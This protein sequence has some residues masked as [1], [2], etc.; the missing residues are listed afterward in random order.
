[1]PDDRNIADAAADMLLTICYRSVRSGNLCTVVSDKGEFEIKCARDTDEASVFI[2][3][4]CSSAGNHESNGCNVFLVP[5]T[6][7]TEISGITEKTR[8][9]G[10]GPLILL[11]DIS[12][13]IPEKNRD[14][15][16]K[17][18]EDAIRMIAGVGLET[19]VV[20]YVP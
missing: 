1:M 8:K 20:R 13:I 11:A 2:S 4:M 5:F 6:D 7:L 17:A 14:D 10:D 3:D 15:Y 12:E 9:S 18:F 19:T 16:L